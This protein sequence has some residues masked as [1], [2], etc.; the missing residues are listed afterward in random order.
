MR[1][2]I[3]LDKRCVELFDCSR[4]DAVKYIQ[5]GWVLV[6]GEVEERPQFKV[7]N[8]QIELHENASLEPIEP[9]TLLL[10]LPDGFGTDDSTE[11]Q[12]LI[13]TESHCDEDYSG[14]HMLNKHFYDLKPASILQNGA[15]GLMVYS[16]D[17][18]VIRVLLENDKKKEEEY[19]VEFSDEYTSE[20]LEKLNWLAH[21]K[22]ESLPKYKASKQSEK[23]M[24]F[25]IE[26]ADPD[27]IETLCK[28]FNLTIV[29]MK[30]IR[31]GRVSMKKLPSGQWRY[32][33]RKA[34]F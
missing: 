30:R 15:S 13:T 18:K 16:K 5:G 32:L 10:N 22:D 1:E 29:A 25:V 28:R 17:Y 6:D 2:P 21:S 34:M 31:I 23:C 4:G 24:R 9:V 27:Q 11:M 33:S 12:Q 26:F 8:Q 20:T 19:I 14:V 3:R 7:Q